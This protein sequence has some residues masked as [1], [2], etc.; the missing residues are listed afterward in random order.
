MARFKPLF[1]PSTSIK[2]FKITLYFLRKSTKAGS[3]PVQPPRQETV[4]KRLSFTHTTF[5]LPNDSAGGCCNPIIREHNFLLKLRTAFLG[6]SSLHTVTIVA[7]IYLQLL[8]LTARTGLF[9]GTRPY[10]YEAE[11]SLIF[12]PDANH[13]SR[14]KKRYTI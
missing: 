13:L 4:S 3:G 12:L 6:S 14:P 2:P 1:N 10:H 11:I 5:Q 8:H 7:C 9:I